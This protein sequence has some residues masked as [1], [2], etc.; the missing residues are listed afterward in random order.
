M[1]K[2]FGLESVGYMGSSP[3]GNCL[4]N[5]IA[6]GRSGLSAV[7][8]KRY[9]GSGQQEHTQ[10]R[11][12]AA[13]ILQSDVLLQQV[14]QEYAGFWIHR[15][16]A[17]KSA[18]ERDPSVPIGVL[19]ASVIQQDAEWVGTYCIK[20]VAL[21]LQ[22][23][24]IVI[25]RDGLQ[26]FTRT[27]GHGGRGTAEIPVVQYPKAGTRRTVAKVLP[28]EVMDTDTCFVV[29]NGRDHFWAALRSDS[30]ATEASLRAKFGDTAIDYAV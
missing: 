23:P 20:A 13:A 15:Y 30:P 19:A 1:V 14:F 18:H 8:V 10:L 25:N 11:K 29:Y 27:F 5:A 21:A 28:A 2:H 6:Q 3:D 22:I 24:I 17:I 26:L 4:F 9:P 16:P 12:A 7:Y